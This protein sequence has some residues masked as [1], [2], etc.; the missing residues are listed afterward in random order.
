MAVSF[1]FR[2]WNQKGSDSKIM[3]PVAAVENAAVHTSTVHWSAPSRLTQA[4]V[5]L[6][7]HGS[8]MQVRDVLFCFCSCSRAQAVGGS[9]F[10]HQV[11][12]GTWQLASEGLYTPSNTGRWKLGRWMGVSGRPTFSRQFSCCFM[13]F[14][15]ISLFAELVSTYELF[16]L[17][18][19]LLKI[20]QIILQLFCASCWKVL[21]NYFKWSLLLIELA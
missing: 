12:L 15:F 19:F 16:Q 2:A 8:L 10:C 21:K 4:G 6:S 14:V 7:I 20:N 1:Y 17:V 5:L 9:C 18:L 13:L 11:S 3:T